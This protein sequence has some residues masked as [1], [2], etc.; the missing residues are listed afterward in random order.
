MTHFVCFF[1]LHV[2]NFFQKCKPSRMGIQEFQNFIE[3]DPELSKN[4]VKGVDL[5]KTAWKLNKSQGQV[6]QDFT[7]SIYNS[8]RL[9]HFVFLIIFCQSVLSNIEFP[10]LHLKYGGGGEL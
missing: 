3:T 6:L 5:V 7:V 8:S 4:G 10:S 1:A 2:L 9:V